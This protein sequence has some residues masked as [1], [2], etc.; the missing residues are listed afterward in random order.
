MKQFRR[1]VTLPDGNCMAYE[2][3]GQH[4]IGDKTS[5]KLRR[6]PTN[7]ALAHLIASQDDS[8]FSRTVKRRLDAAQINR[9][10]LLHISK[11]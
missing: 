6:L 3:D 2:R 7:K 8:A 9:N 10:P 4:F 11:A 1:K 5:D